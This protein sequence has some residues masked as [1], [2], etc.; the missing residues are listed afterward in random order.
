MNGIAT[1]SQ[2]RGW[3]CINSLAVMS[4]FLLSIETV[5]LSKDERVKP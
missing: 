2:G 4:H 1:R 5:S 3:D